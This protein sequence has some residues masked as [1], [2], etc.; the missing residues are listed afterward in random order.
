MRANSA[1]PIVYNSPCI[2][3]SV[4]EENANAGRSV[5]EVYPTMAREIVH[6]DFEVQDPFVHISIVGA[7]G[8]VH[9]VL[10][11]G[12]LTSGKHH[13]PVSIRD[14]SAGQYFIRYQGRQ[15]VQSK[16]FMKM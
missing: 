8:K 15:F 7:D 10:V 16:T 6:I 9:K 1:L 13:L 4:H 14:L 2:P 11:S 12:N 5:L 3:T